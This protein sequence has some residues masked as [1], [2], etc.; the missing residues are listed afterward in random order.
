MECE[1][2]AS[3]HGLF[4]KCGVTLS[5]WQSVPVDGVVYGQVVRLSDSQVQGHHGVAARGVHESMRQVV[6][7]GG[8]TSV[9]VPVEAAASEGRRVTI[10]GDAIAIVHRQ[11]AVSGIYV[12]IGSFSAIVESVSEGVW[13]TS[14][15][16]LAACHIG[17]EALTTYKVGIQCEDAV[18]GKRSAIIF[19]RAVRTDKH[20][21]ARYHRKGT[22]LKS[23]FVVG[24]V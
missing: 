8:D 15:F 9:F 6:A 20:D 13:T 14:Y 1:G 3:A 17:C 18:V 19:L 22:P 23:G 10:C 2:I 11:F 12:I 24:V 21:F 7:A 4:F 5:V 16:S